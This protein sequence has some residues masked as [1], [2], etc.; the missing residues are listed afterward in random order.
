MRSINFAL[1][2]PH[3][4]LFNPFSRPAIPQ[5]GLGNFQHIP[6]CGVGRDVAPDLA[7]NL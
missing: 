2:I 4:A 5:V 3:F 7:Q 1:G 6:K